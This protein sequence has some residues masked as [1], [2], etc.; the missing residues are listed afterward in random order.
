QPA[1]V[2]VHP[3]AP[4]QGRRPVLA[5]RRRCPVQPLG[6]QCGRAQPRPGDGGGGDPLGDRHLR[7]RPPHPLRLTRPAS[8]GGPARLQLSSDAAASSR[9]YVVDSMP[10]APATGQ[11]EGAA[12]PRPCATA[13]AL[14]S[15]AA[16]TST[17]RERRTAGSV[18]VS[19]SGGGL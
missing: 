11:S 19:R 13:S 8:R 16:T 10:T 18:N 1:A 9:R 12:P 7:R 3:A 5:V 17:W 6:L 2:A 4:R 15:P 14:P